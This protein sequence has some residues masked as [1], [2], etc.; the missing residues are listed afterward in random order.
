[1]WHS[2]LKRMLPV[3][4]MKGKSCQFLVGSHIDAKLYVFCIWSDIPKLGA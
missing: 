1:M 2:F 4:R 3:A